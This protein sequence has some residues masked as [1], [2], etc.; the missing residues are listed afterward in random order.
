VDAVVVDAP[1]AKVAAEV[2]YVSR[3][4]DI[5]EIER[6]LRTLLERPELREQYG[7]NGVRYVKDNLCWENN[8][9]VLEDVVEKVTMEETR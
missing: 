6:S 9:H 4:R 2:G 3:K 5:D 8:I 1:L 7:R